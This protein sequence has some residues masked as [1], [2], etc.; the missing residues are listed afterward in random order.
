MSF[1]NLSFRV[2][3]VLLIGVLGLAL[4]GLFRA[5]IRLLTRPQQSTLLT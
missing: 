2:L 5:A 1:R 3:L 4:D